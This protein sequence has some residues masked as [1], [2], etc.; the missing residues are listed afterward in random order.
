MKSNLAQLAINQALSGNWEEAVKT[1]L[2]LLKDN[3]NDLDALN[4]LA[5]AYAEVG[6]LK[7]AITIA[8]KVLKLDPYNSIAQKCLNKWSQ[9]KSSDLLRTGATSSTIF[10]EEPG[11][12]K[13]VS[14]TNISSGV[15]PKLDCGDEVYLNF[16]G[17]R[18]STSTNDKKYIGRLPDDIGARLK[19]MLKIGKS[20]K[21]N[22]KSL[23]LNEIKVFIREVDSPPKSRN[24]PSFT[25]ERIDYVSFTPPELVHKNP[26][27]L[28]HE[29]EE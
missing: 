24:I 12:T 9:L 20:Y 3:K 23:D 15:I 21:V 28:I 17:H 27:V 25:S 10:I 11:K 16:H 29:E 13:I 22:I 4:R 26:N 18:V 6:K 5:K 14:L 7:K 19:K 1:N 8:K 2:A